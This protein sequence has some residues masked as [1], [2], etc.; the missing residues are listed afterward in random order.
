[1]DPKLIREAPLATRPISLVSLSA[2][3]LSEKGRFKFGA[4]H[5]IVAHAV[6]AACLFTISRLI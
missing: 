2:I 6:A 5:L 4:S 1:M 3:D